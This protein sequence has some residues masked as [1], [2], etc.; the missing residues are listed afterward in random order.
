VAI[1]S[2]AQGEW[3]R[4][5]GAERARILER[6]SDLYEENTARLMALLVRE[7]GK[8]LDNALADLREAVD[9][10]RYY[11]ELAR[12]QFVEPRLLAH[13][14]LAGVVFTGSNETAVI[15]NRSLAAR[16]GAI[17]PFIAETGGMNAM[18]VDSSA[19]PEQTVRDV[20]S[21][22]FDSAGQRCSAAR[23]LFVQDD[24]AERIIAMLK[25]AM[26]EL[27]IGDPMDYTTDIGPVIDEEAR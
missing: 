13:P 21:S 24:I 25:G 5:G 26:Q 9:F 23:L 8:T 15:I 22:A 17:L 19:L 6:A 7:A 11:A 12:R 18:I 10:L 2:H 3:D 20:L 4:R 16:N 14:A 1:A 27:S